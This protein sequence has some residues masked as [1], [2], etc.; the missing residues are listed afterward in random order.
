MMLP[1]EVSEL[2]FKAEQFHALAVMF[3]QFATVA[4]VP[5]VIYGYKAY[6]TWQV[7]KIR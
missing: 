6:K 7:N 3:K 1:A 5:F 2:S 4:A